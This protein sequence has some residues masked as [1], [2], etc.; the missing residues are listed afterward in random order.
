MNDPARPYMEELI[1]AL[2]ERHPVDDWKYEVS[3]GDTLLGYKE[4]LMH[5]YE[6]ETIEYEAKLIEREKM[7]ERKER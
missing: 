5:H 6:A 1:R 2:K 4:W 3:N 7:R